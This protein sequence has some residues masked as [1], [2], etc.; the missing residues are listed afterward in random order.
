LSIQNK[1][2]QK[3]PRDEKKYF[4][5]VTLTRRIITSCVRGIFKLISTFNI[6]GID[7]LPVEGPVIVAANHLSYYDMFPMQ[8][9]LPRPIFFM[10]KEEIFRNPALDLLLRKLG[11]FPVHRGA[12]DQW[13]IQHAQ[14][15][16]HHN[17]V[18]AIFPEGTRSYGKGLHTA[19]TG[20][21][22]IAISV[23]CPIVPMALEGPQ[24]IFH[25]FPHRTE[26]SIA[27]GKPIYPEPDESFLSLTD[28]MMFALAEMLPPDLRGVYSYHPPGF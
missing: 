10:G 26:I 3:D 25:K 20:T 24:Y 4:F 18:L 2:L 11:A 13:A 8:L 28:R 14:K 17:Q 16:L 15:V 7:N 19:K 27:I 9:V 22:R 1:K 23:E 21:A 5:H 12:Q 6:K